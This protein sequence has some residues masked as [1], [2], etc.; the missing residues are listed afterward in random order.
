MG[1]ENVYHQDNITSELRPSLRERQSEMKTA[2]GR[3]RAHVN[4]LEAEKFHDL[5]LASG[6]PGKPVV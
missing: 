5:L 4:M 2:W 3:E 1:S 6:G